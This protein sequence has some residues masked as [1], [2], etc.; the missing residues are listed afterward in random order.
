VLR[1]CLDSRLIDGGKV[2]SLAHRPRSALQKHDLSAS[3]T[4]FFQRLNKPLGLM[5]LEGLG[6]IKKILYLVESRTRDLSVCSIMHQSLYA[7]YIYKLNIKVKVSLC[8][9]N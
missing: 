2:A 4:H 3:G 9:T 7:P 1:D 8:L 6:K 5:R